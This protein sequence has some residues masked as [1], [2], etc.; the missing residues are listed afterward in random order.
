MKLF[1]FLVPFVIGLSVPGCAPT[2]TTEPAPQ[3]SSAQILETGENEKSDQV[4]TVSRQGDVNGKTIILIPGLASGP[5]VWAETAAQLSDYDLRLVHIAG[6]AGRGPLSAP[7]PK[8]TD[9]VAQAIQTHLEENPGNNT[10]IVGHSLGGFTALK[11][12]LIEDD[13][14]KLIIVDSLPY[15]AEMMMP[16]VAAE[17]VDAMAAMMST[18]IAAQPRA[19]FDRQQKAGVGRMAK[20][21]HKHEAIL[22]ASLSSDQTQVAMAMGELLS[23]DLREEISQI[24]AET[25]VLAAWDPAM[26]MPRETLTGLYNKQYENLKGAK[27]MVIP[28][29]YHFI[30][31]D[32]FEAFFDAVKS[33]VE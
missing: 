31:Y 13:I 16:N 32:Q 3:N 4:I 10:T 23:A 17:N 5:Q 33:K 14:E 1:S 25:L 2:E 24:R 28:N 26:G 7:D 27:V 9:R 22:D 30:M 18:Q 8:L 11:T 15:L 19:S 12:A 29:S 20:S 21:K 6:F